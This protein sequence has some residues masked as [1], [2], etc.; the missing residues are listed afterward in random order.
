MQPTKLIERERTPVALMLYGVYL[1]YA[2]RSL[3]LASRALERITRRSHVSIWKWVQ[4]FAPVADR[5]SVDRRDVKR[6]FV[7]ETLITIRGREYWLWI[8]YEPSL[9]RC[10][11]MRLS[12]ERTIMICYLFLKDVRARYGRKAILTDEAQWYNEACRWLRLPHANYPV[13]EKN[14]IERFIQ[15]VKDRTECF[16]DSFPCRKEGC[17]REHV[18]N[19]LSCSSFTY[20]LRWTSPRSSHSSAGR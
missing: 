18:K 19:W 3:R 20:I 17:D 13:Q 5:F 7:D 2:S 15:K 16:D 12:V 11:M 14:L 6:I 10:L 8:A 4:R 1:Y 9:H